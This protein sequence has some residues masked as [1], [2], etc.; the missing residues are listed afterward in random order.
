MNSSLKMSGTR[1]GNPTIPQELSE[2]ARVKIAWGALPRC[3]GGPVSAGYGPEVACTLCA[4]QIKDD[5]LR[6]TIGDENGAQLPTRHF[7]V[8]CFL[9]WESTSL[10]E[11]LMPLAPANLKSV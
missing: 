6:Y 4:R 10:I 8:P 7:H 5:E 1:L 9:A 11:T 2:Q 3:S